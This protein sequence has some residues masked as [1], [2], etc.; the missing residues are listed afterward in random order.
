MNYLFLG[1]DNLHMLRKEKT[2]VSLEV[3]FHQTL[4]SRGLLACRP[5]PPPPTAHSSCPPVASAVLNGPQSNA[6]EHVTHQS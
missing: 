3:A 1:H 5:S 4:P 2:E 6:A